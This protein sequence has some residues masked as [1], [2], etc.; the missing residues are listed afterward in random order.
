MRLEKFNRLYKY[1][2]DKI[3]HK[4]I[5]YW[6]VIEP[7]TEGIYEGDCEDYILTLKDKVEG[8]KEMELYYCKL[9]KVGHCIGKID[10]K[11]IDCNIKRKVSRLPSNYTELKKYNWF[12]I[13][14]KV[15]W[16][17]LIRLF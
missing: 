5:E 7:N 15:N 11:W 16:A 8:F 1:K 13:F 2:S 3:L 9:N 10:G 6:T 12:V 14:C 4:R 17:R